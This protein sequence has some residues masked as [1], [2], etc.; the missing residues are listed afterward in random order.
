[1]VKT[2]IVFYMQQNKAAKPSPSMNTDDRQ[3]D[4]FIC[5]SIPSLVEHANRRLRSCQ[6][7]GVCPLAIAQWH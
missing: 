4:I 3:R 2:D 5:A 1:M 6:L 7:G